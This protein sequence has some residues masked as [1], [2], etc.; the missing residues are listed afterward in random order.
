[1]LWEEEG[2]D[3]GKGGTPVGCL[4]EVSLPQA[5][6]ELL[7]SLDLEKSSCCPG[8]SRVSHP[9]RHNQACPP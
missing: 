9:T 8:L 4:T 3:K 5:V 1:M 7:E 6:E 2:R